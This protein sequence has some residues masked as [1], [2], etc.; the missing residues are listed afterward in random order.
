M[1]FFEAFVFERIMPLEWESRLADRYGGRMMV[2]VSREFQPLHH[3]IHA[4]TKL[5]LV[6]KG[7]SHLLECALQHYQQAVS[8]PVGFVIYP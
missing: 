7:Y 1:T 4:I 8:I 5:S 6:S 2:E 3:A